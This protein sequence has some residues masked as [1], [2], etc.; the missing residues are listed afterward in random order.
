M[1]NQKNASSIS[2]NVYYTLPPFYSIYTEQHASAGTPS[3]E[4]KDFV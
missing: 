1:V 2:Q 3:Q 4:L